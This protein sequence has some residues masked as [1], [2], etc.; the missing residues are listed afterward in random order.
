MRVITYNRKLQFRE[1]LK[2]KKKSREML[3]NTQFNIINGKCN[4]QAH[5]KQMKPLKSIS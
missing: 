4:E 5:K 1:T 2:V 3:V